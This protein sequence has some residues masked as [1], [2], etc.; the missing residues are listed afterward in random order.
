MHLKIGVS[1]IISSN[2][3]NAWA[4]AYWCID[5]DFYGGQTRQKPLNNG[6]WCKCIDFARAGYAH[7]IAHGKAW[8]KD[9]N[10][11]NSVLQ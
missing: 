8:H 7:W 4:R 10:M 9:G 1:D 2:I 3:D 5:P 6:T 11:Q